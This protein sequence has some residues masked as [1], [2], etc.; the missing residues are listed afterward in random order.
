MV[1]AAWQGSSLNL[2]LN[3][4]LVQ[5]TDLSVTEIDG[6]AVILSLKAAS[7]FDLNKVAS[8]IWSM[9]STPRS[10]EEILRELSRHHDVDTPTLAR[11]VMNFLQ[12]LLAQHLVR[13]VAVEAMR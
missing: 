13:T 8:E 4:V 10:V 7:Y 6:R 11:D 2:S 3:T 1:G 12:S 9:L 5:E